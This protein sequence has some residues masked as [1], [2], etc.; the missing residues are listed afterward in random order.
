MRR[1]SLLVV[2]PLLPA[3]SGGVAVRPAA[4]SS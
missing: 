1:F 2:V 3:A 4:R